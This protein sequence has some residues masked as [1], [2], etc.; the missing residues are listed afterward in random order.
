MI[1]K[2]GVISSDA[3]FIV[4]FISIVLMLIFSL[5]ICWNLATTVQDLR[6]RIGVIEDVI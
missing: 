4:A 6:D 1:N 2:K 5:A 3:V